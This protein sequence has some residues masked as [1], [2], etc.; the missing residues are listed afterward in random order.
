MEMCRRNDPRAIFSGSF[1]SRHGL[2]RK[3]SQNVIARSQNVCI[4][5]DGEEG[6]I[7]RLLYETALSR[8]IVIFRSFSWTKASVSCL[9][10][11]ARTAAGPFSQ[12]LRTTRRADI[13]YGRPD[14]RFTLPEHNR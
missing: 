3:C 11:T 12:K 2:N 8:R 13:G 5:Y 1:R 14:E 4:R 10:F 6:W 9:A 7:A